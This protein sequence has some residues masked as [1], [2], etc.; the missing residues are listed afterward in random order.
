MGIL[1]RVAGAVLGGAG[2]GEK[3]LDAGIAGLDKLHLTKEEKKDYEK[4]LY[5]KWQELQLALAKNG[6]GTAVN[7]RLIAWAVVGVLLLNFQI[8]VVLSIMGMSDVV[9]SIVELAEAFW[10]G[11]SFVAI[12]GFYFAP[13]LLSKKND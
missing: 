6:T 7:R 4:D 1:S 11:Q 5:D 2:S 9:K 10:I 12:I 13:H 3:M 8:V